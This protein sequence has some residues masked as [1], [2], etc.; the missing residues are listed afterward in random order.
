[1][2][3]RTKLFR[4]KHPYDLQGTEQL[5]V[6]AMAQNA[7]F[8]YANCADYRRIC[9]M[10]GVDVNSIRTMDDV[11]KLPVLPTLYFKHH[12]LF[13]MPGERMLIKATSSGTSGKMSRIGFDTRSLLH[14]LSMVW[15]V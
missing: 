13:A 9:D 4:H 3:K 7:Q 12:E 1:M 6:A 2:D 11:A 14:G 5:F 8:Q 10:Q 15:R